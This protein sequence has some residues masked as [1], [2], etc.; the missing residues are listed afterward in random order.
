MSPLNPLLDRRQLLLAGGAAVFLAACSSSSDDSTTPAA[1]DA[2]STTTG[3]DHGDTVATSAP[4][5]AGPTDATLA[6]FTPA[7]APTD[8]HE[9]LWIPPTLTGSVFDL[10]I[11]AATKQFK[12]GDATPTIGYNGAEFWGPTLIMTK[13]D[14]VSLRV[15][16][17]LD[18]ETTTHWHGFHIPAEMDGG[19][20]QT[21]A[22]GATWSPSFE[23]KNQA[24]TFWYHP[25][26]HELTWPQ[27]NMGAGGFIIVRDDEEAA[28]ALPRTYG[29]DDIPLMLTS[30]TFDDANGLVLT[31]VTPYG[32]EMLTNGTLR[33]E[34]AVP[35]QLVRFRILN[36][37]IERVYNLGFEDDRTFHVIGTDGGLLNAPAAVTRLIVAPG[38]RYE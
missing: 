37:E 35:A 7:V 4:V 27:M 31:A 22:V 34:V 36:G 9:S 11:A 8:G 21:I 18:E 33:A 38:E 26:M 10:S 2:G 25:H 24:A 23:V 32:D 30:R 5:D 17:E 12:D 6:E 19:P 1:T 14:S 3:H 28:L 20:H 16:N 29:V 15:N 13:G